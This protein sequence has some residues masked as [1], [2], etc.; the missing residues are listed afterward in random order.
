MVRKAICKTQRQR[1]QVNITA[2]RPT[3]ITAHMQAHTH[4]H[5]VLE[6]RLA[7][8]R[9]EVDIGVCELAAAKVEHQSNSSAKHYH[10]GVDLKADVDVRGLDRWYARKA[11]QV[12]SERA[13]GTKAESRT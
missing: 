1:A 2:Q 7:H 6:E 13:D 4:L 3:T 10:D 12:G 11:R 5:F 9:A 8:A